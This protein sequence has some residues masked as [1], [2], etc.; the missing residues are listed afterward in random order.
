MNW[1]S[2]QGSCDFRNTEQTLTTHQQINQISPPTTLGRKR[3]DR[4]GLTVTTDQFQLMV[5]RFP[6]CRE[7][8]YHAIWW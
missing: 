1:F 8:K 5:T 2:K 4:R 6:A 7:D 3:P